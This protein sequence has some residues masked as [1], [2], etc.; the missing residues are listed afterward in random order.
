MQD[1]SR[2]LLFLFVKEKYQNKPPWKCRIP[3]RM[4][5]VEKEEGHSWCWFFLEMI[6]VVIHQ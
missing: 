2:R 4:G 3:T 1:R 6:V 5:G